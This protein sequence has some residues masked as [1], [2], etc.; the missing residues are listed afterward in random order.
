MDIE[1]LII[2]ITQA[3]AVITLLLGFLSIYYAYEASNRLVDGDFK[4]LI[5]SFLIFIILIIIGVFSMVVYHFRDSD[6]SN[7]IW[8]LFI[9]IGLFVSI[10]ESY[11][12]I[13]FGKGFTKIFKNISNKK[14]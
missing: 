7:R 13:K 4:N 3:S 12:T 11:N 8:V 9:F 6:I 14:N 10:Y 1:I 5:T 2:L